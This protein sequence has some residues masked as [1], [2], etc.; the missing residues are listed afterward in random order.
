MRLDGKMIDL[1]EEV[2]IDGK[3]AHDVDIVIDRLSISSEDDNRLAEAVSQALEAGQG[4]MSVL[5]EPGKEVLFSQH[6][7]SPKSGLSYGPLNPS[8]FSFNHPSGMCLTCQGLGVI[9]E[10]NLDQIINP[11]LSIAE[12]CCSIASSYK[13][14]R[15]GNIYNNLAKIYGFDVH[16]PWKK[17]PEKAKHVFL[18]GTEKKWTQMRFVHP[19]KKSRWTEY[20]QWRGV[21]FEAKE[22]FNQAQSDLYRAKMRE[23]MHESLCPDCL[24]ARI[25]PYP[26]ATTVGGKRIAQITAMSIDDALAFFQ[27]LKL[28]KNEKIIAEE[29]LKEIVQRLQFLN[30]VGL[31]YLSL[32][33]TAP[34]LSGGESQRVRLASQIGS[35]LVGATY[36]LDEPSIGLHP[37]DNAK[38]LQTLKSLRDKGNTV[39][40]VEHDEETIRAAD[41][42]VD[43]GPLA[44][45]FGGEIIVQGDV[46][47]LLS[48]PDSLTGAYLSGKKQIPIPKRR[49]FTQSTHD[50]KSLASQF[51]KIDCRN[52]LGHFCRSHRGF[53]IGKIFVSSAIPSIRPFPIICTIPNCLSAN[54]KRSAGSSRSIK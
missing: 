7:Y 24:G 42:I 12:D 2:K 34:T 6:A 15:Y 44:G 17:L 37:R 27:K 38:L 49:S 5:T 21:L 29:L 4:L 1:S 41:T 26:A 23:L 33:R 10:F 32:E 9:Q 51:K 47:E 39:I 28:T 46:A 3:V 8:D 50:R 36:V 14:V 22:R 40:V 54:T 13:T 20:V 18:Y 11:D 25:R 30:G 19:I 35:G 16:A 31:H 53:G 52:S 48:S 45:Q 43:V